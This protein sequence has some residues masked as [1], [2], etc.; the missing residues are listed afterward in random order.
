MAQ[1]IAKHLE[2]ARRNLE[3]NKLREAVAEYQAIF[4][5]S[6]SNQEAI[7]ALADLYLRLSDPVS[8][9]YFYGLQ[10]DRLLETGD[11]AKASAIYARFLRGV[12][13]PPE[14]LLR[15]ATALQK[16]NRIAEAVEQ[17]DVT[18]ERLQEM[19]RDGEALECYERI[20]Q[21][22][23]ENPSRH[24]NIGELAAKV[25]QVDLA[26][27][28]FLRAG[29]LSQGMATIDVALDYFNRAHAL[30]PK[31][32]TIA[33]FFA[34]AR[35]RKGDAAGAVELLEPYSPTDNDTTFL[36]LFG[37][38]LLRVGELDR[39]R[40]AFEA[41]YR[42]RQD[43]FAKLFE[44]AG[45][46]LRA[47]QDDKAVE[48]L[49]QAKEWMRI[50][51]RENE[52]AA[53]SDRMTT[54]FPN[55]IALAQLVATLYEEL[56]RE[57]KYFDAL[58][59]LFDLY[60]EAEQV[61]PA[62]DV[63]DRLVDID[64][65]DYRNQE[66]IKRLEGKADPAFLRNILSRA[67][68]AATIPTRHE[69]FGGASNERAA[70]MTEDV[71][72]Q[73]ALE[74]LLVQVEIFLQYSLHTK[75]IERLERIADM[76]PNEEEK[77]ERL[78]SVYERA[79]W[80]PKGKPV[81][82]APKSESAPSV[83]P[84]AGSTPPS[85]FAP[86]ALNL[87]FNAE[88]QRDLAEIAE[89]TRIMYRQATPRDVVSAAVKEIGK[90]LNASRCIVSVSMGKQNAPLMAEFTGP[91]VFPAGG[92]Q[93]SAVLALLSAASPD[94]LGGIELAGPGM[95][96][97]R[98][99]KLE[100][101]LGVRLV[102]KETQTP[103]GSLL[104]GSERQRA[105]RPNESFFLQAVGDQLLISVNHTRTQAVVRSLAFADEKTGLVSRGAYLDCLLAESSRARAQ[106]CPLSLVILQIDR[107]KDLLNQH[108][109]AALEKYIEQLARSLRGAVRQTD[110]AVKY[111]AWSLAF[112][113]PDTGLANAKI[114]A[115]KL[116]Q[117]AVT[118]EAPWEAHD[119]NVSAI[120]AEATVRQSDDNEDRVTEWINRAEVGLEDVRQQGGGKL[121]VLAT[122]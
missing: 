100:V 110:L 38:A 64:P 8:A 45:A 102:D 99:L 92:A 106:G 69:G 90:F 7:Q 111:T 1:D 58:V 61:K 50:A 121:L 4:D 28:S 53:Q 84:D 98:D 35:L 62:C 55:S 42:Q 72:Q 40:E 27:R 26:A 22:D 85:L 97:V 18:A 78:R 36:A 122:P 114:L 25:G 94:A 6:P 41:F 37:E 51:G 79:N 120:V 30:L 89:F 57:A 82:A 63:L 101:A 29:Q 91:G 15:Y 73:Q 76:F 93:I 118:V 66:R 113:L 11:A 86:A 116:C 52:F 5:E 60:L 115:E 83:T 67:A 103:A 3:K 12:E 33:L 81:K 96:A 17:F 87:G 54:V 39:A 21:L 108:G 109:D 77:N 31:D 9:A 74:D 43:S 44:L 13:Q 47:D 32:R 88:T 107:G 104:I 48:V 10:F 75:A 2:R 24:L 65:Y 112:I 56:N 95:A 68:K 117:V 14:R 23:S 70:P 49:N 34:E 80:W 71:R 20:S 16:Q 105:W 119:L 46:Y 59:R 19:H